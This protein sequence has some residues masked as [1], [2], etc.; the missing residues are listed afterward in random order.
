MT[1]VLHHSRA[2]GTAKLVMIGIANHD[3]DG[4]SWPSIATLKKY[5]AVNDDR[6]MRRIV[7]HLEQLGEI[8]TELNEGGTRR[9][10]A[11]ERTNLYTITLACPPGCSG[12]TTHHVPDPDPPVP[13]PPPPDTP[14]RVVDNPP[15]APGPQTPPGSVD[16]LPPGST[17]PL[18]PGSVDPPNRPGNRPRNRPRDGGGTEPPRDARAEN[19]QGHHDLTTPELLRT[20]RDTHGLTDTGWTHA[21]TTA[22]DALRRPADTRTLTAQALAGPDPITTLRGALA[23][24]QRHHHTPT[25][26]PPTRCPHHGTPHTGTCPGCRADELAAIGTQ[27]QNHGE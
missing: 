4:G 26:P 24:W 23:R 8:R 27:P 15:P 17:D 1:L 6:Y 25:T 16:P 12:G 9:T 20:L 14:G 19:D 5:A 10:P 7:R 18:P 11:H 22:V 21:D 13:L 3:G 2:T